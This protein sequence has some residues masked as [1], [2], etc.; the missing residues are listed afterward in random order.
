MA[1]QH[2]EEELVDEPDW[3]GPLGEAFEQALAYLESLP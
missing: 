3:K 2:R 1:G